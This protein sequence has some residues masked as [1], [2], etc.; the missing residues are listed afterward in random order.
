[1]LQ[2]EVKIKKQLVNVIKEIYLPLNV[3]VKERIPLI[4][5]DRKFCLSNPGDWNVNK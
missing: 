3:F 1:M 5:V 2:A 4:E